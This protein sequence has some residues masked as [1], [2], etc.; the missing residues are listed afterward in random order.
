MDAL[1][2]LQ[3]MQESLSTTRERLQLGVIIDV[4]AD[5]TL[6]SIRLNTGLVI[7][8]HS[9]VP[10]EIGVTVLVD[11]P[12]GEMSQAIILKRASI[13]TGRRSSSFEI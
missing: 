12:Y 9:N 1:G 11:F 7:T 10:Y 5:R 3:S 13:F 6:Y 4:T 2:T 8:V